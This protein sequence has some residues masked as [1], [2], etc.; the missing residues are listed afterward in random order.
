MVCP[1]ARGRIGP[2]NNFSAIHLRTPGMTPDH[3]RLRQGSPAIPVPRISITAGEYC[4]GRAPTVLETFLGSCVGVALYD[5]ESKIGGL[6]HVILPAGLPRKE[7]EN[8]AAY[9]SRGIPYLV[10]ALLQAG[11]GRQRLVAI[12]AGGARIRKQDVAGPDLR[13]GLRNILAVRAG[14]QEMGIP[15]IQEDV[16]DDFGRHMELCLTSGEVVVRRSLPFSGCAARPAAQRMKINSQELTETIDNLKPV[17][18]VA[19]QSLE[20]A[21]DPDCNYY[22]L[23]RLILQDQVLAAN[24]L[25]LV[26]SAYYG[27]QRKVSTISQ[28]LTLLGLINFRKLVLQAVAH[29]LFARKLFAYSME[30]GALFHHSVVCARLAELLLP[31]A[32]PQ[33][34]AE[35]YLAGL[36]HDLGKVVFERC[37]GAA[38]PLIVDRVLFGHE[39]FHQAER[40]I[41]GLDHAEAGKLL[42]DL[43]GLPALF[44]QTI[45]LHHQPLNARHGQRIVGVVHVANALCNM[46]GVGLAAD[47]LANELEPEVLANLNLNEQAIENIL[48]EVPKVLTLHG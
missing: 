10:E 39:P 13:I 31:E 4:L 35:A 41:L 40:N 48:T 21:R 5:S 30:E 3:T 27:P 23:E 28:A 22:Q 44:G 47:S 33:E 38:F 8:P 15:I 29:H 46:L 14:L 45:A 26:N 16:G 2:P 36:F 37:A 43:W 20:V 9:A 1:D 12:I 18:D 42:A 19:L 11:A 24:I 6:L 7:E 17:S 32:T 25:R 34:R